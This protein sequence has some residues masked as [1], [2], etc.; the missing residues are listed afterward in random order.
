LLTI[1]LLLFEGLP[2]N[3]S[4][5]DRGFLLSGAIPE[6]FSPGVKDASVDRGAI[7]TLP[8]TDKG[9]RLEQPQR[10]PFRA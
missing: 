5:I 7:I 6:R 3:E 4:T 10:N 1:G 2:V 8:P 9:G